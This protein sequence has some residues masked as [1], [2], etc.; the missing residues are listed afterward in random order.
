MNKD[1][2]NRSRSIVK[3]RNRKDQT[4]IKSASEVIG[5]WPKR[6]EFDVEWSNDAELEI[7][8]LEFLDDDTEKEKE[9]KLN[10]L[11]IYNNELDEREKRKQ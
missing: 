3:N 8:E 11:K 6:G 9:L 1:N 7:A 10:A 2:K 5:Y 4:T